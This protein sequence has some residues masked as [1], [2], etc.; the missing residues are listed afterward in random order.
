VLKQIEDLLKKIG[1]KTRE[2]SAMLVDYRDDALT[3]KKLYSGALEPLEDSRD[4]VVRDSQWVV[5]VQEPM[6]H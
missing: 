3:N 4:D 2:H 6:T 1:A 5:L